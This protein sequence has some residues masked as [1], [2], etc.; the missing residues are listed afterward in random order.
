MADTNENHP[1]PGSVGS[2]PLQTPRVR[3]DGVAFGLSGRFDPRGNRSTGTAF[4]AGDDGVMVNK[5]RLTHDLNQAAGRAKKKQ[6]NDTPSREK[7][8]IHDLNQ[9]AGHAKKKQRTD[10][11]TRQTGPNQ[12]HGPP[13]VGNAGA[14]SNQEGPS[15]GDNHIYVFIQLGTSVHRFKYDTQIE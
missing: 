1:S 9:A 13:Q 6:R 12:A 4:L 3:N 11:P 7:R 14:V 15:D 10:T 5:K 8:L 2:P